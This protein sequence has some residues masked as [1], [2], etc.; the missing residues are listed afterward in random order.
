MLSTRRVLVPLTLFTLLCLVGLL[1]AAFGWVM[2]ERPAPYPKA[3]YDGMRLPQLTFNHYRDCWQVII[4]NGWNYHT[5]ARPADVLYWQ[6]AQG[7]M[8][9]FRY[10]DATF[11]QG[12]K[13]GALQ[14]TQVR[15]TFIEPETERSTI[16]TT[17]K[18][19]LALGHCL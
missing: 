8:S 17:V 11:H 15:E 6:L 3:I 9:N 1:A 12:Q 10:Y 7:Y 4:L 18:E 2:S 16:K 14:Y 5:S 19:S 13:I